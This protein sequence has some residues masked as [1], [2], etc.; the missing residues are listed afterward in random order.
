MILNMHKIIY[1]AVLQPKFH[2]ICLYA[3]TYFELQ[4]HGFKSCGRLNAPDTIL[5]GNLHNWGGD[6]GS[7]PQEI[8]HI[9]GLEV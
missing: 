1:L 3:I 7:L 2:E 8:V 4:I 9:K 6:S 5:L